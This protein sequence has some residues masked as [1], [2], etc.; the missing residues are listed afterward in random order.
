MRESLATLA[1]SPTSRR[2]IGAPGGGGGGGAA[3]GGGGAGGGAA[4]S[5]H[6][7]AAASW[8]GR[9]SVQAATSP[10]PVAGRSSIGAGDSCAAAST[11]QPAIPSAAAGGWPASAAA[12][13]AAAVSTGESEAVGA[14]SS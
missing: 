1:S 4:G 2:V 12:R 3:G 9:V 8:S 11:A 6:D 7:H 14:G 13:R 10:R 5:L